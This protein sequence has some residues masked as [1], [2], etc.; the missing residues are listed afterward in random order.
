MAAAWF[1]GWGRGR[2]STALASS[3]WG[4][5]GYRWLFLFLRPTSRVGLELAWAGSEGRNWVSLT[6]GWLAG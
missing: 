2:G 5:S 1:L 4:G 6:V 3:L